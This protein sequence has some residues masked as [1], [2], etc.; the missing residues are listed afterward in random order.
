MA[1]PPGDFVEYW[2][3]GRVALAGGDPY[4]PAQLMPI[5]QQVGWTELEPLMMWNPPWVLPLVAPLG[6]LPF[7]VARVMWLAGSLLAVGLAAR[8]AWL[9]AGGEAGRFSPPLVAVAVFVPVLMALAIGQ[10]SPLILLGLVGFLHFE[11]R[12]AD[13]AAGACL[14]LVAAKPQLLHLFWIALLVW[15][16]L[17]GRVRVLVGLAAGLAG[18]S[19]IASAIDPSVWAQY[20]HATRTH[21][22][23]VWMTPT[24]GALLRLGLG[25]ERVWLQFVPPLLSVP[26]LLAWMARE[27]NTFEWRS[28]GNVV[29]LASL[30]TTAYGWTFDQVLAV[31][32]VAAAAAALSRTARPVRALAVWLGLNAALLGMHGAVPQDHWYFWTAPLLLLAYGALHR[33]RLSP[34]AA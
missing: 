33:A 3:A 22:P 31:P 10:I 18:A 12:G 26:L 28:H 20:L 29:V 1:L 32:A 27:R 21:P 24:L 34:A 13:L 16:L 15:A 2:S 4:D 5:Q 6:A 9:A 19:A 23:S 25:T 11:R 17:R 14:V 8:Q 7:D 30:A